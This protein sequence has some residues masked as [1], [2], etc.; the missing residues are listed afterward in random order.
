[1]ITWSLDHI[2]YNRPK[3]IYFT[4]F[5]FL[6]LIANDFITQH[7]PG[8][9]HTHHI[10]RNGANLITALVLINK[11]KV[12][13]KKHAVPSWFLHNTNLVS[14]IFLPFIKTLFT[15]VI[16]QSYL[17]VICVLLCTRKRR[18]IQ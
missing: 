13:C 17:K 6:Y 14:Y 11:I 2:S 16:L 3:P 9:I 18:I 12:H 10:M 4:N 1:M 15:S 8:I 7:K 5:S